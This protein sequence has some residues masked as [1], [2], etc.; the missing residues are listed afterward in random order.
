MKKR[1][2]SVFILIFGVF[3]L[4]C[5][6]K[7]ITLAIFESEKTAFSSSKVELETPEITATPSVANFQVR[8]QQPSQDPCLMDAETT[9]SA[10]LEI[11]SSASN[12]ENAVEPSRSPVV[13]QDSREVRISRPKKVLLK[14]GQ[15]KDF[16]I[17]LIPADI[18]DAQVVFETEDETIAEISPC[19]IP[20]EELNRTAGC[21]ITGLQPGRTVV[22]ITV[23]SEKGNCTDSCII[24][25]GDDFM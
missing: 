17:Y 14:P 12:E 9:S 13:G 10:D 6:S 4:L 5:V 20:E 3:V 21:N 23:T 22:N 15:T 24:I 19:E 1:I 7:N 16:R 18:T 2:L 8:S 25:V 11:S